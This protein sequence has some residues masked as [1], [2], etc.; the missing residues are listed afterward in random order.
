M[1]QASSPISFDPADAAATATGWRAALVGALE[2]SA[3]NIPLS[4]GAV[5]LVFAHIG[6][7][8]L[9]GAMLA[10]LL[11][12]AWMQLANLRSRR[13]LL[14]SAR[15]FEATALAA[16]LDRMI[17][18]LPAWGLADTV[19]VRLALLVLVTALAGLVV[20]LLYLLRADRFTRYIPA[21]VFAGFANSIAVAI[22]LSQAQ[23][24]SAMLGEGGGAAA[25]ALLLAC[26]AFAAG[27]A[28]RRWLPHWPAAT[29]A[30]AAGLVLGLLL[31]VWQP[32]P[33]LGTAGSSF[34]LPVALADFGA[35]AGKGV[36]QLA[37]AGVVGAN[38]LV[39][40]TMMF[41]NTSVSAQAMS[42]IDEKP[43]DGQRGLVW[44]A[45]CMG[46]AGAAGSAPLSGGL[47]GS[48]AAAR[49]APLSPRVGL[50]VAAIIAL[51]AMSG[52]LSWV[53]L[54]AVA[55][56]LVGEAWS[57]AD[58]D[59]LK[60]LRGWAARRPLSRQ[61]REDLA[62]IGAVTATAVL[63]NMVAAVF[64]GLLFGLLLFAA[65]NARRPVRAVWNGAQLSS[66]C[67][68]S[69]AD[70][71]LLA[72]HGERIRVIEL[73]GDLF[74]GTV[75]SLERA[76]HRNAND[77][78]CLVIDWSAVRHL[79]TSAAQAVAK[80]HRAAAA[81]GAAVFHVQP[82]DTQAEWLAALAPQL[83]DDGSFV[84]DLDLAL[85]RA[86]NQLLQ[87]HAA[88]PSHGTTTLEE[89]MALLRGLTEA[90]R[91]LLHA[92][93]QQSFHRAGEV[94][95]RAGEPSDR[96]LVVLQG[97]AAVI[98]E[99]ADGTRVRLAGVRRGATIGEMGFLDEAP[100]S[101]TVVA[102][103]DLLV[104]SL[105]RGHFEQLGRSHPALVHKLLTNIA[106]DVAA[107]LRHTNRLASARLARR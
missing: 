21:P 34:A 104:A 98:V 89:A 18:L 105:A 74:F 62:L 41:I 14:Y 47:Q 66:N 81:R 96:L 83:P 54:A 102:Q 52:V 40:G 100:R 93:M 29:C 61:A 106:L 73:E 44:A 59:S 80:F 28:V 90:E 15:F 31:A 26:A 17:A 3:A 97:T 43:A 82:R 7:Q 67:A 88:A 23:T 9:P 35:L 48:M 2:G 38:A 8:V 95:V 78:E 30:M 103:E 6:P 85:E 19:G 49:R 42:H 75:N 70:L 55:G 13:P 39:L 86:E 64:A 68:R 27:L 32:I 5:T 71:Q 50:W 91:A 11:G 45:L 65:R 101:A 57:M 22:L 84:A 87:R 33:M 79:D 1:A 24:L 60:L 10:T 25:A 12:L 63:L 107:R 53:P 92:Q 77:A 99:A 72:R 20:G 46:L 51:V 16:M 58:R 56:A 4:L 69:R 36:Q 37:I 94:L 76:L